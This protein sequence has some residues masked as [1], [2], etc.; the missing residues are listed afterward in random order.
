VSRFGIKGTLHDDTGLFSGGLIDSL[1][2]LALVSF[3][4]AEI[5][6]EIPPADITIEHFDSIDRIVCYV[7]ALSS[8]APRT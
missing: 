8:S 6:R 1:N 5:G 2:V 4:E 3:V 7:G